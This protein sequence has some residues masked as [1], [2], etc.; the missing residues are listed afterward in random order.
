MENHAHP[1]LEGTQHIEV[2]E[3]CFYKP[4]HKNEEFKKHEKDLCLVLSVYLF[5]N[6]IKEIEEKLKQK[7]RNESDIESGMIKR[8]EKC[9]KIKMN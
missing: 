6:Q 9:K 2:E 1:H 3:E 8:K 5:C 7:N 4:L